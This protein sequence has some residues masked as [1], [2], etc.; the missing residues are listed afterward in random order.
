EAK[1][2]ELVLEKDKIIT[3]KSA[4]LGDLNNDFVID[5]KDL[6]IVTLGYGKSD[7]DENWNILRLGDINRDLKISVIDI[8][9]IAKKITK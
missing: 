6:E 7:S 2:N 5:N 9:Y 8:A 3:L 1:I 4:I